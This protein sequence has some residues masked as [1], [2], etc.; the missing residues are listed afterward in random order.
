MTPNELMLLRGI[1]SLL[2]NDDHEDNPLYQPLERLYRLHLEQQKRLGRLLSIADG[3]QQFTQEDLQD[4]R[5]QYERQLHRERKLSRISDRYQALMRE[6]N[7]ALTAA[8]TLDPL[9]GLANRRMLNEH[10]QQA[11]RYARN[12]TCSFC[13]AM[14]DVDYFKRINDQYGHEVG[15]HTLI[16]LAK[17]LPQQLRAT[18]LC[19][20]WGGEEFLVVLSD[21]TLEQ[22]QQVVERVY[23]Q[24]RTVPLQVGDKQLTITASAG[25]AEYRPGEGYQATVRRADSALMKA[26]QGGRDRYHLARQG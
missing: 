22:A 13:V 12:G 18:D 25:V 5:K 11:A 15:D 20:R 9:T 16:E 4:I 10:L 3:Y 7:L 8:S 17:V 14:F 26:K 21:T 1:E 6:R 19:G 2:D 23:T 24:L